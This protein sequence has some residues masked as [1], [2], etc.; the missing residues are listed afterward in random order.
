MFRKLP[1]IL[2]YTYLRMPCYTLNLT[3]SHLI[4]IVVCFLIHWDTESRGK[5]RGLWSCEVI[6]QDSRWAG[7]DG[8]ETKEK[9]SRWRI[10]RSGSHT[11]IYIYIYIPFCVPSFNH[12]GLHVTRPNI[13]QFVYLRQAWVSPTFVS[14]CTSVVL[15][16]FMGEKF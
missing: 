9:E 10:L 1:R 12:Y 3:T 11:H 6:G 7:E 15:T 4:L 8:E 16:K 13:L 14:W 2:E 5:W